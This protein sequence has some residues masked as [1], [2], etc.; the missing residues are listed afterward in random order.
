MLWLNV[1]FGKERHEAPVLKKLLFQQLI[2]FT[3][4]N[5]CVQLLKLFVR[6][7]NDAEVNAAVVSIALIWSTLPLGFYG[8]TSNNRGALSAYVMY[9]ML[10][11]GC[12]ITYLVVTVTTVSMSC[13]YSQ[14][15]LQG[16]RQADLSCLDHSNCSHI[17]IKNYNDHRL[18][19]SPFC[20]AWGNNLCPHVLWTQDTFGFAT[21]RIIL[22]LLD[23]L[24]GYFPL[25]LA[26]L[27]LLRINASERAMGYVKHLKSDP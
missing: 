3:I 5:T 23:T 18:P 15:A 4:I 10:V 26:H 22:L 7:H 8:V 17:D 2:I 16:C 27:Y 25:Y 9:G 19:G 12:R 20:E 6:A 1:T 13:Q 11:A 21:Y 24:T 14:R